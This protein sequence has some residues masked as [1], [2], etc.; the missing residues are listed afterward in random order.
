MKVKRLNLN[1]AKQINENFIFNTEAVKIFFEESTGFSYDEFDEMF[2]KLSDTDIEI[3]RNANRFGVY[4][5]PDYLVFTSEETLK[6]WNY[7]KGLE[8]VNFTPDMI[9]V[10]GVFM[11]IYELGVDERIDEILDELNNY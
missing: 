7:Y 10:S 6:N 3:S 2:T 8:Y 11:A 1:E 5:S 9:N 4:F